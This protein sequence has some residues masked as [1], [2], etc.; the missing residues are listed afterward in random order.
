MSPLAPINEACGT[1]AAT[2]AAYRLFNNPKATPAKI[3][4]PHVAETTVRMQAQDEPV[5]V[6]QDTVFFSYGKHPKTKGLG[7]IGKSNAAGE[8]GLIMHNALAFTSSGVALG[9]LSQ[10]I[11]ARGEIPEEDYVDKIVRLQCTA[12]E[13]KESYKWLIAL[14][15]TQARTPPGVKV[16]SIAD[17][18]SDFFEFLT[19]AQA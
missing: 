1:W 3:L 5:L 7:P 19:E 2:H 13:E 12:I 8:R 9:V 15:E 17:R 14:R 11:W 10:S 4:A 18:E 6:M 16:V